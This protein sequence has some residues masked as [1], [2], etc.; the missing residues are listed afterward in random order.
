MKKH[1]DAR[2]ALAR[3]GRKPIRKARLAAQ[4]QAWKPEPSPISRAEM[5]EIVIRMIG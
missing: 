1:T 2:P 4:A 5:R 3:H